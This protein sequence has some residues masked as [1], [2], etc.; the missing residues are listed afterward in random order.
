MKNKRLS[1]KSKKDK[2]VAHIFIKNIKDECKS[3]DK[4]ISKSIDDNFW[5]LV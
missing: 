1:K 4:D 5:D 3:I 2:K